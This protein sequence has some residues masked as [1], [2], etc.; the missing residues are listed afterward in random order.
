MAS[1]KIKKLKKRIKILKKMNKELWRRERGRI[2]DAIAKEM[3]GCTQG[4]SG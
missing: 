2:L 3:T 1:K 4:V